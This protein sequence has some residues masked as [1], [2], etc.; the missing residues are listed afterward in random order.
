[1]TPASPVPGYSRRKRGS[2]LRTQRWA[3]GLT[4]HELALVAGL[5]RETIA[6]LEAGR[7]PTWTTAVQ[8]ADV[9]GCDP[10]RLFPAAQKPTTTN[11]DPAGR[12][13][14]GAQSK[15]TADVRRTG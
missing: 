15:K 9:L 11:H 8:L 5:A 1:M 4:Q 2:R 13:G 10:R 6:R 14:S 7:T 12:P 3:L